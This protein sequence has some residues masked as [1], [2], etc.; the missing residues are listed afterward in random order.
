MTGNETPTT[1]L[2]H[3]AVAAS[4]RA[5]TEE[6]FSTMLGL[7]STPGDYAVVR[8]APGAIDGVV[9]LIGL[10]GTWVGTG[11]VSCSASLA[12]TLSA[13]LLQGEEEGR[14]QA[15]DDEVLDSLA[16]ITNMILGNV[17]NFLEEK[18]GPMG[19]S[20]PTVIFGRNFTAR[21]MGE[22]EW[23]VVPFACGVDHLEVRLRMTPAR[24]PQPLRHGFAPPHAM[25]L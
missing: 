22:G 14:R 13:H 15:V 24:Q 20:I 18:L 12:C 10:A 9:A 4:I 1:P 6:V 2:D 23:V 21:S 7:E 5:A 11:M 8:D 19:L 17:K 25:R 3:A 16:E